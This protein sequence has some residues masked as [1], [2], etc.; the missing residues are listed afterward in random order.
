M[1]KNRN[2]NQRGRREEIP[3][4]VKDFIDMN[5]KEFRKHNKNGYDNLK[6]CRI[7]YLEELSC[8]L[9]EII[10]F[11][12]KTAGSRDEK[13]LSA[14]TKCLRQFMI[15][16][17][18]LN[19]EDYEFPE[20]VGDDNKKAKK[21]RLKGGLTK[22]LLK[23]CKEADFG[24]YGKT[25]LLPIVLYKIIAD[26]N[27]MNAKADADTRDGS[28]EY[29]PINPEL[30]YDLSE[31]ILK[32]KLK[33]MEKKEIDSNLAFDV[34]SVVPTDDA[35]RY[36]LRFRVYS[37]LD[38]LYKHAKDKDVK[39]GKVLNMLFNEDVLQNVVLLVLLERKD[40]TRGFTE[41]QLSVY[42]DVTTWAIDK[43]EDMDKPVIDAVLNEYVK[44]RKSDDNNN[45]DSQRRYFLS[46]IPES[47]Y[48]RINKMMKK[49]KLSDSSAEKYL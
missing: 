23:E 8:T 9:D 40:R 44:R 46:S 14:R 32:K 28:S 12:V 18:Y 47:K 38:L 31:C 25:A 19:D 21:N 29:T 16:L 48:P 30:L 27:R 1:E 13:I 36:A 10:M 45:K 17:P 2:R 49:F 3:D 24:S 11:M 6:E 43:L 5:F 34:L 33:R 22:Y 26:V 7:A 42:N 4:E 41:K 20:A 35:T 37:V 39:A 15:G